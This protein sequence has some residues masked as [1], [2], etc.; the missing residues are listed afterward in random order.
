[1]RYVVWT[2]FRCVCRPSL[3]IFSPLLTS[4]VNGLIVELGELTFQEIFQ[5]AQYTFQRCFFHDDVAFQPPLLSSVPLPTSS[6]ITI[7]LFWRGQDRN[8]TIKTKGSQQVNFGRFKESYCCCNHNGPRRYDA[9]LHHMTWCSPWRSI[10]K[11]HCVQALVY[12][13][14]VKMQ[15]VRW[16]MYA[17][18][19]SSTGNS[20]TNEDW[21]VSK[22]LVCGRLFCSTSNYMIRKSQLRD[23]DCDIIFYT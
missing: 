13:D 19:E 15:T 20:S 4:D 14:F 2:H 8:T 6:S 21:W 18:R 22:L 23:W 10:H 12:W 17:H 7:N 1:M 5:Q 9:S 11:Q 16:N 3:T